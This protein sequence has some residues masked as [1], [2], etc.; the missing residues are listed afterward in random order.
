MPTITDEMNCVIKVHHR[1][2]KAAMAVIRRWP[3]DY[4]GCHAYVCPVCKEGWL[5]GHK[6]RGRWGRTGIR[7]EATADAL[8]TAMRPFL[9]ED[10]A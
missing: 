4:R 8:Y 1:T 10:D 5:V 2:E 7:E 3:D 6:H 9:G